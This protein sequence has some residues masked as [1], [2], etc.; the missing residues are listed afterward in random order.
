MNKTYP[1]NTHFGL[2]SV[3]DPHEIDRWYTVKVVGDQGNI[4]VY[5]DDVLKLE[6]TD[7]EP[8]LTGGIAIENLDGPVAID[9]LVVS[10]H[11][12]LPETLWVSTGG[13][14]GGLGYDVR[15]D[16]RDSQTMFVSDNFAGVAKTDNAGQIWYPSNSGISIKSGATGDGINI[17]CLTIDP[18]NPDIIWAGPLKN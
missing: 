17:F 4:K 12:A 11:E 10:T 8:V 7:S 16:P 1:C 3:S 5:V 13:P 9:D 6:Y 2:K 15:I 18:G 14:L